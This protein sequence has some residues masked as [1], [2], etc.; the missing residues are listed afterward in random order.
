MKAKKAKE[1]V[2]K[3]FDSARGNMDDR[4]AKRACDIAFKEG[5]E[6]GAEEMKEKAISM[7][8]DCCP[9][10]ACVNFNGECN[11]DCDYMKAF[12]NELA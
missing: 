8:R 4:E 7:H 10:T 6:K 5:N 1:Y 9:V 2:D 3:C 12:I 11:D